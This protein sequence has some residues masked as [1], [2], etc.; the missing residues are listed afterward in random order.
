M[1]LDVAYMARPRLAAARQLQRA[2][3]W[4]LALD[5]LA[6]ERPDP[7]ATAL[8]AEIL[9]D[10]HWWRLD[11]AEEARTSPVTASVGPSTGRRAG[12]ASLERVF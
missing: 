9:V 3:R 11:R 8:R 2:G 7:S 6:A 12:V 10:R 4:D 5:L 1:Q